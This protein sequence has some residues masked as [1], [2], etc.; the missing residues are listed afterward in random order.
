MREELTLLNNLFL[1]YILKWLSKGRSCLIGLSGSKI[2]MLSILNMVICF[3]LL[4]PSCIL[5]S[6]DVS[7]IVIV[8]GYWMGILWAGGWRR[9]MDLMLLLYLLLLLLLLLLDRRTICYNVT[10][11]RS[12]FSEIAAIYADWMRRGLVRSLYTLIKERA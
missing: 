10:W 4:L 7:I 8:I 9:K 11:C 5:H 3:K 2:L 1:F 6:I 12:F